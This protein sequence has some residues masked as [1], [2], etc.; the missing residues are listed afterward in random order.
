M[1]CT[2]PGRSFHLPRSRIIRWTLLE[3]GWGGDG[4]LGHRDLDITISGKLS[5]CDQVG[6]HGVRGDTMLKF[7][8]F[9]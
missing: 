8:F 7:R 2:G 4:W 1:D 6:A 3:V 9:L 5:S